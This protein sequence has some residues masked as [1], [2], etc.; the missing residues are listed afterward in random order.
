MT[1]DEAKIVFADIWPPR[2]TCRR[3]CAEIDEAYTV[4]A[5]QRTWEWDNRSSLSKYRRHANVAI[6]LYLKSGSMRQ[7]FKIAE[8]AGL[9]DSEL[10][11]AR[12]LTSI[13][14]EFVEG[15]S[16]T[17]DWWESLNSIQVKLLNS[18]CSKH[19]PWTLRKENF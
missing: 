13:Y 10:K 9:T 3:T 17:I 7:A 8:R 19:G 14:T 2:P 6:A 15:G 5:A 18:A 16:A 1:L 11:N 12:N 4:L